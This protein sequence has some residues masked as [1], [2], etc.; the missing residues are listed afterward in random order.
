M[1]RLNKGTTCPA[2]AGAETVCVVEARDQELV[3]TVLV[4][5]DDLELQT[6]AQEAISDARH[7]SEGFKAKPP[8]V[9][10]VT[11]SEL[12]AYRQ[13]W[14]CARADSGT[15]K[16]DRP[17]GGNHETDIHVS[18]AKLAYRSLGRHN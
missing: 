18:N 13:C 12:Q 1:H 2:I 8:R 9:R 6:T 7:A 14:L 15:N 10:Q 3:H 5:V 11:Q 16:A 4:H 17:V